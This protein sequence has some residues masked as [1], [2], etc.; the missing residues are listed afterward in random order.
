[1]S[2][3]CMCGG[4]LQPTIWRLSRSSAEARSGQSSLGSR[5]PLGYSSV[6]TRID[7]TM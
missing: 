5:L 1:M 2:D 4:M 7:L 6:P 3:V